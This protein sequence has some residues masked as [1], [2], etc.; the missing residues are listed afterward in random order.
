MPTRREIL[1]GGAAL[2]AGALAP[3]RGVGAAA[4]P[5]AR[6]ELPRWEATY[7]GGPAERAPLEPGL[8]GHDYTPVT[9]P[10]GAALPF[11]IVD[12]VKVFHL[13]I[14]EVRHEF[15]PGLVATCW[16][17][18]GR[19]SSSTIEA[20]EGERVR[21]Y[22]TN[23][24]PAATSVH[25]HGI[26]LPN[27]MDGV[28]GLNQ[29]RIRPGETFRYEWTLRQ[30][31]SFMFHSHHDEMTQFAMGLTGMFVIHPRTPVEDDHVDRDFAILLGEYSVEVGTSRPN[32]IEDRSFNVLTFNG[33]TFPGTSPLVVKTG[34]RVRM[35]IGN[36]SAMD[37][38]P[39][40]VHG[41]HFRVT[42]TD[43][44]RIPRS[45]QWPETSVLVGVGQVRD[46][47]FVADA[48]G[49]WAV[50]CHMTHH[51]MNQMGHK[52]PNLIGVD[53][54]GLD[55]RVRSLLPDYMTMGTSGMTDG[56]HDAV[57]PNSIAM[58]GARGPFDEITMGGLVTVL[59]VRDR[60]ERYDRDPGWYRHPPG[61]VARRATREELSRDGIAV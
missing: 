17:Y 45:A 25:W 29:P 54:R 18:D 58:R 41:H 3:A 24:L 13:V 4:E 16:G 33:K 60:L 20:V 50:H 32:P 26:Y 42:A 6:S 46:I 7:S 15:A 48:P 52:F 21:I 11:R 38:H 28:G 43:G 40:H 2:T 9:V 56:M 10:D 23:R 30:H 51:V 14:S 34:D 59:K 35:R 55:D 61:T 27:G 36:L 12:G 47:E 5:A 49:D 39:V 1:V 37:H 19:V 8:P 44:D 57:P 31:G 22:V 53:A